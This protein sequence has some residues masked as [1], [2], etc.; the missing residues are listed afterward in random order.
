MRHLKRFISSTFKLLVTLLVFLIAGQKVDSQTTIQRTQL[1]I[2]QLIDQLERK[3][4][5][6]FYYK[7]EWFENITF[8]PTILNLS[9]NETLDQIQTVAQISVITID[10]VLYVFVHIK[11]VPIPST[12]K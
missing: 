4:P 11:H 7:P 5:L 3:Y 8:N 10:S 1:T 9:F 12:L 2:D 6:Q